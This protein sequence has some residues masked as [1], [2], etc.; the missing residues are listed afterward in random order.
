MKKIFLS[1]V[2]SL[3]FISAS[4]CSPVSTGAY[5]QNVTAED[6]ET[7][8]TTV[9]TSDVMFQTTTTAGTYTSTPFIPSGTLH[10]F[11]ENSTSATTRGTLYDVITT[12]TTVETEKQPLTIGRPDEDGYYHIEAGY[13][14][15]FSVSGYY[16][17]N[18]GYYDV[19]ELCFTVE[20]ADPSIVCVNY[21]LSRECDIWI[22]ALS[23]GETTVTMT[24]PDG[25]SVSANIMVEEE[26]LKIGSYGGYRY[27][28]DFCEIPFE[29]SKLFCLWVT[30]CENPDPEEYCNGKTWF[31]FE[32]ADPSI[33]KI[34]S[35]ETDSIYHGNNFTID[36]LSIGETVLTVYAP[37]CRSASFRLIVVDPKQ[38]TGTTTRD[39]TITT[40]TTEI[41]TETGTSGTTIATYYDEYGS[42]VDEFGNLIV[43][44]GTSAIGSGTTTAVSTA[45]NI[46]TTSVDNTTTTTTETTSSNPDDELPQTGNSNIFYKVVV[47]V[48]SAMTITGT[49]MIA[50]SKKKDEE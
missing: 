7:T 25:R 35:I 16:A 42:L 17:P 40:T 3:G 9:G 38:T 44:N 39:L 15:G 14:I 10:D 48:A 19:G 20:I 27:G 29:D 23:P 5:L 26:T 49:A 12:S 41:T 28:E 21:S 18:S 13:G 32:I 47:G 31:T 37:D 46:T 11:I 45:N 4:V 43:I 2:L 36:A 8:T 22:D 30:G 6:Y 1:T 33:A 24:A 50:Y 34:N